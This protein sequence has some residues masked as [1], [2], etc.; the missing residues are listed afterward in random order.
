MECRS[1][2]DARGFGLEKAVSLFS[3]TEQYLMWFGRTVLGSWGDYPIEFDCFDFPSPI[4]QGHTLVPE[5]KTNTSIFARF[6]AVLSVPLGLE[7]FFRMAAE[8]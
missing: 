1:L 8:I 5:D 6:Y 2:R 3:G 7:E 4:L